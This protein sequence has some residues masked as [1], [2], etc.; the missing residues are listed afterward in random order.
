M[1]VFYAFLNGL[2]TSKGKVMQCTCKY[3]YSGNWKQLMWEVWENSRVDSK[4]KSE[5]QINFTCG[6]AQA[7]INILR[8]MT[9]LFNRKNQ[10]INAFSNYQFSYF[11]FEK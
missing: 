10:N 9:P 5:K 3:W 6:K 2:S 7:K 8:R 1:K 4:L 11:S